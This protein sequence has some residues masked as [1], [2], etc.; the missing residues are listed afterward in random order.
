MDDMNGNP[1]ATLWNF[2]IHGV[3][4]G[5]SNMMFS[6]DIMGKSHFS[7]LFFSPSCSLILKLMQGRLVK[8]SRRR[9]EGLCFSPMRMQA[10]SIPVS[11]SDSCTS[12]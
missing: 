10:I 6:G 11:R 4:Y 2:A 1:I 12:T 8:L 9:L 7:S 3:C 5:P